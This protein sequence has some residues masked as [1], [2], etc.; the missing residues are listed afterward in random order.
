VPPPVTDPMPVRR[1]TPRIY[2]TGHGRIGHS[3]RASGSP[4]APSLVTLRDDDDDVTRP[5]DEQV[6][7][8]RAVLWPCHRVRR[9]AAR[10]CMPRLGSAGSGVRGRPSHPSAAETT[11][12]AAAWFRRSAAAGGNGARQ[13]SATWRRGGDPEPWPETGSDGRWILPQR[14][15][16]IS[17]VPS[18]QGCPPGPSNDSGPPNHE[19]A[20]PRRSIH[21]SA[22]GPD[23]RNHVPVIVALRSSLVDTY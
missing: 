16:T 21:P 23:Q 11:L 14:A 4:L 12:V 1:T 5:A 7:T 15:A 6:R 22:A 19:A 3:V 2:P 9:H 13:A 17:E 10:T 20:D 18:R 8:A